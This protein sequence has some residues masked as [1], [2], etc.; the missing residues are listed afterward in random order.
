MCNSVP[1]SFLPPPVKED[2]KEELTDDEK[3][4][5]MVEGTT[6]PVRMLEIIL[7]NQ[8]LFGYDPYYN[9]LSKSL[10]RQAQKIVDNYR[11]GPLEDEES[12][13]QGY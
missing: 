2:K 8:G 5:T 1:A 10:L 3:F 6:D 12:G 4:L 11:K 9:S 13:T 7:E